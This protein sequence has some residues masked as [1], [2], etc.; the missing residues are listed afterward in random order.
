V[1]KNLKTELVIL[2]I[3]TLCVFA[4]NKIDLF[5]YNFLGL[6]FFFNN[7]YLSSFFIKIT[8]LGNSVWVFLFCFM[9]YFTSLIL[10]IYKK[11]TYEDAIK[12]LRVGSIFLFSSSIITG[13]ITQTIKHVVGRPRPN[14]ESD[15]DYFSFD[16]FSLDSAF[17]SFPSGHTSTIFIAALTLSVF[18]PKI[19]YAYYLFA[20]IVSLSRVSV[21]AHYLTD[22][23]GGIIVAILSFKI[24]MVIFS[25]YK[26]KK[27]TLVFKKLNSDIFLL[28]L[29]LFI[30]SIVFVSVGSSLDIYISSLF[31]NEKVFSLQS[32]DLIT[33][34]ARKFFLLFLVLYLLVLPLV[35][36]YTPIKK[37]YFDFI[38]TYK[39]IF[40]IFICTLL[41]NGVVVNLI[42]KNLWGRAR[43][44]DIIE[45]GGTGGFTPWYRLSDFCN[46]NCSFVSG[47]ASIGFSLIILYFITRNIKFFWLSL[48]SGFFLGI[49]RIMEGGHFLSDILIA[50]FLIFT[51]SIIQFN[52]TKKKH[53]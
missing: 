6:S 1:I 41:N 8:V 43:P 16:L 48:F 11:N 42:L 10:K 27:E 4:T 33:I 36:L 22:V 13:L 20:I 23:V 37:I 5:L 53:V 31:F 40:F 21:N 14:Y 38:F 51:L 28:S 30:I 45:L 34:L 50:G 49:I 3:L 18:T 7:I 44:N 9:L 39:N 46:T 12:S 19:K 15:K 47:D 2:C 25:K 29:L 35:S 52:I 32:Y 26:I 17:H 24:S